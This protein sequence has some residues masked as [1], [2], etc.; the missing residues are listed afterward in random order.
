ML[1]AGRRACV[2]SA[3][4]L[5][6]VLPLAWLVRAAAGG[7]S[8]PSSGVAPTDARA[9]QPGA[10]RQPVPKY[11][12][13]I[14]F[15]GQLPYDAAQEQIGDFF[16]RK[17]LD[18]FKVRMLTDKSPEKRFRG[19]AF[20]EFDRATDASR[21]LRLDHHL[22]GNRRIRIERT[23]T[24]GGN[25]QKRKGRLL[26]S[27]EQ[28]EEE[29]RRKIEGMLDRIFARRDAKASSDSGS[30]DAVCAVGPDDPSVH[31]S[32]RVRPPERTTATRRDTA[33]LLAREDCDQVLVRYLCSLPDK[34]AS[35]AARACSRLEV[36]TVDNRSAFAMGMIKRKL[37]REEKKAK[38]RLVISRKEALRPPTAEEGVGGRPPVAPTDFYD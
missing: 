28:Q 4:P 29:R 9:G 8:E 10:R 19:I 26:R 15:V 35:K 38:K 11:H 6:L 16:R 17:G 36:S 14:V 20:V 30:T 37:R 18:D 24:G 34:I 33:K 13:K 1:A 2:C 32:R 27:K 7:D 25:N 5:L 21:A 23:A 31:P 22:F 12:D 3:P